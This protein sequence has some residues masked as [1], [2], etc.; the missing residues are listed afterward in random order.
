MITSELMRRV[1]KGIAAVNNK[2]D[3][4]SIALIGSQLTSGAGGVFSIK[5][6]SQRKLETGTCKQSRIIFEAIPKRMVGTKRG[7]R[8]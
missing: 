7:S 4:I 6:V 8:T 5:E 3:K 2:M 1:E